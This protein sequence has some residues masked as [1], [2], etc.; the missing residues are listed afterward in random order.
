MSIKYELYL[1]INIFFKFIKIK[2]IV[3][4]KTFWKMLSDVVHTYLNTTKNKLFQIKINVV[5]LHLKYLSFYMM[6]ILSN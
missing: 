4:V 6:Q 3:L 5:K 1:I 2:I